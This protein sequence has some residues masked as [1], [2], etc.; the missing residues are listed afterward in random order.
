M[1]ICVS[2]SFQF[3]VMCTLAVSCSHRMENDLEEGEVLDSEDE[4]RASSKVS[5]SALSKTCRDDAGTVLQAEID[6][7]TATVRAF[8]FRRG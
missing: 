2:C 3:C 1:L 4:E 7:G 8:L 6:A 5:W